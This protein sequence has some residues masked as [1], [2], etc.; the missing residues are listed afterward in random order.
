MSD[1]ATNYIIS[2]DPDEPS[3]SRSYCAM[4]DKGT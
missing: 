4:E 1:L 2:I 3:T